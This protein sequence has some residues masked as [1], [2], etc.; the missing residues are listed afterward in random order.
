MVKEPGKSQA[1]IFVAISDP[2][3]VQGL[4]EVRFKTGKQVNAVLATPSAIRKAIRKYYR[5]E[6]QEDIFEDADFGQA[7]GL[8]ELQFGSEVQ[9]EESASDEPLQPLPEQPEPATAAPG[10]APVQDVGPLSERAS[11]EA[12]LDPETGLSGGG[13]G[14]SSG[15]KKGEDD[16]FSDLDSLLSPSEASQRE[17]PRTRPSPPPI[18]TT[19]W[20]DCF[21]E[22]ELPEVEIMEEVSAEPAPLPVPPAPKASK[23]YGASLPADQTLWKD[24]FEV[25][26]PEAL[27]LTPLSAGLTDPMH[28]QGVSGGPDTRGARPA[29]GLRDPLAS[30][31]PGAYLKDVEDLLDR[32]ESSEID[33]EPPRLVN[34]GNLIAAVIRLLLRKEVI[35]DA[36]LLDELKRH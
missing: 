8:D 10:R 30:T 27:M 26:E 1:T 12:V 31:S 19:P 36:D 35:S 5:G 23:P 6:K 34:S 15:E 25:S 11:T 17:A 20:N 14:E 18:Q 21:L 28:P 7:T 3:N 22:D 4:D 33:H 9:L 24:P 29:A 32:L 13:D 16:P 2:S